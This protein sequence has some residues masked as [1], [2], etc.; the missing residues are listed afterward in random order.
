MPDNSEKPITFAFYAFTPAECNYS[1]LEKETLATIFAVK[2][3]HQY[4]YVTHFTLYS[5]HKPLEQLL[6]EFQQIPLL[7]SALTLAPYQYTIKYKPG[8]IVSTADA[9]SRLPLETTLN[10]SQ[11]SL[12]CDLCHLLNHLD[13]AI[14]MAS[15]IKVWTDKDPLLSRVRKLVQCGWYI[16]NPT[17]DLLPLHT[18]Y[19]ELTVLDKCILLGCRVVIPAPG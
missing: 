16:T 4:L 9:L 6:G 12:P 18:R 3:F 5:D 13:Q 7:A 8:K 19:T 11:V 10:D 14:V 1:Q 2:R 17:A 15:Q